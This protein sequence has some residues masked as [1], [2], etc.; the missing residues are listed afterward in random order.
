MNYW[1]NLIM[2][3]YTV[4]ADTSNIDTYISCIE[5]FGV[6]T[7]ELKAIGASAKL[8]KDKGY[9]CKIHEIEL[10]K[11]YLENS[12]YCGGFND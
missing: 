6:F 9:V 11:P 1:R 10:D 2:K 12:F 7:D 3:V 8:R 5:L 4:V